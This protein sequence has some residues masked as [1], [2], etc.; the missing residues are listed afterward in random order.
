ML[1][2]QGERDYKATFEAFSPMHPATIWIDGRKFNCAEQYYMYRKA[3]M[4]GDQYREKRIM[5]TTH[6][7]L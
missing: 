2:H 6:P 1:L 5:S 4:F 3:D 7:Y